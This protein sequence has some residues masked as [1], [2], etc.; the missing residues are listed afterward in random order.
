[1]KHAAP[2]ALSYL[3]SAPKLEGHNEALNIK[4]KIA[5]PTSVTRRWLHI[6][7]E[8]GIEMRLQNSHLCGFHNAGNQETC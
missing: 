2:K 3:A 8:A 4:T 1:M 7:Q 5:I 6:L